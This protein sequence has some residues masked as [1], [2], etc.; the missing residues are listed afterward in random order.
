MVV[1]RTEQKKS[2]SEIMIEQE[3]EMNRESRNI[4]E[5]NGKTLQ[6]MKNAKTSVEE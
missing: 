5:R 6:T 3:M 4:W 1:L 2:I